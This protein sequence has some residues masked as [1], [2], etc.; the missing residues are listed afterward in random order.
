MRHAINRIRYSHSFVLLCLT[1]FMLSDRIG[2]LS[3]FCPYYLGCRT[4]NGEDLSY[5]YLFLP[6]PIPLKV[7]L[8]AL[9][10]V[11]TCTFHDDVIKS[12]HFPRYRPFARGIHWSP[13]NSPHKGQRHKALVISLI[14]VWTDSWANNGDAGDMRRYRSHYDVI[15]MFCMYH[16]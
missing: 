1:I 11:V 12:K 9:G 6:L 14:S 8:L 13:V 7:D 2:Y 10:Q 16:M 5:Q 4:G 3:I 15:V